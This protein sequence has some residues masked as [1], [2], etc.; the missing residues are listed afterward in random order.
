MNLESLNKTI[1]DFSKETHGSTDYFKEL[2]F[3][4]G[5]QPDQFAP[6]KFLCKKHESLGTKE[7]LFK[8][9]YVC[10]AF[11]LYDQPA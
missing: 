3:V 10:D 2:I 9:G 4:R 11:D 5:Q 7:S 6:L 8:V 1:E